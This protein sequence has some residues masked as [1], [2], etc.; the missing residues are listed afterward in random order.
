MSTT[1]SYRFSKESLFHPDGSFAKVIGICTGCQDIFHEEPGGD[2]SEP[3]ERWLA[4]RWDKAFE[5]H[6]QFDSPDG[7]PDDSEYYLQGW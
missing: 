3:L 4:N 2:I 5:E 7:C 6:V 1:S